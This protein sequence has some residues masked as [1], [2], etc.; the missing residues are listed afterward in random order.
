[1]NSTLTKNLIN[2]F[3]DKLESENY[4]SLVLDKLKEILTDKGTITEGQIIDLIEQC[5][6][7]HD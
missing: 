5:E 1:M 7:K 3:L 6:P 4:P 2:N